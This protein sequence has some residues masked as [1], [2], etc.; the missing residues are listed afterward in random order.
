[1]QTVAL[2][3]QYGQRKKRSCECKSVLIP[4]DTDWGSSSNVSVFFLQPVLTYFALLITLHVP[5]KA[6]LLV[7]LRQLLP[8]L[9]IGTDKS[10]RSRF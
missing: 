1:M 5:N 8:T 2:D 9:W 4:S 3:D 7:V 10:I 6:P